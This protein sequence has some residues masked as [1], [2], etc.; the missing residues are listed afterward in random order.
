[1]RTSQK[2]APRF[3]RQN[4]NSPSGNEL[5]KEE[6]DTILCTI[7]ESLDYLIYDKKELITSYRKLI[8]QRY[9]P[10]VRK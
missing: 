4:E 8:R 10:E 7:E 3:A 2:K 5:T 6:I 1:M 9:H